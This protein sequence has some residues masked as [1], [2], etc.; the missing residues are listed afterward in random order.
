MLL[1]REN[2]G[3][4]MSALECPTDC[5]KH[6]VMVK[7]IQRLNDFVCDSTSNAVGFDF[8]CTI[9]NGKKLR[10]ALT[11]SFFSSLAS[12]S[13]ENSAP[14]ETA[15]FVYN[16]F[17][18]KLSIQD[19]KARFSRTVY[20][21][22][23]VCVTVLLVVNIAMSR[24]ARPDAASEAEA[25]ESTSTDTDNTANLNQQNSLYQQR[26]GLWHRHA[27]APPVL[28]VHFARNA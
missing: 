25:D 8:A 17:D 19:P 15:Y 22:V 10:D 27:P 24:M 28:R 2:S 12:S 11:Q 5:N 16:T 13:T 1:L 9:S 4:T 26:P 6:P 23:V 3:A 18:E 20:E 7:I 21:A 14:G